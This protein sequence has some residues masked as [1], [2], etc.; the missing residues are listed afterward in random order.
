FASEGWLPGYSFPRLPLSAYIPARRGKGTDEYLSRPR[1]IA[2]SQFVPQALVY[3]EGSVYRVN[4]VMI[5]VSPDIDAT[6]SD[7]VITAT[8][9]QCSP[10]GYLH[11]APNGA[12]PDRCEQ[13]DADLSVSGRRYGSLLRMTSVSPRRQ[14]KINSNAEE[15]Q[16][17]GY[18]I[19]T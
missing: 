3:H 7:P 9:V 6:T 8:A 16:R 11:P 18:E 19:R 5:P 12:G 17:R 13:C 15:R 4:R 1:F 2:I 10:C 14:D